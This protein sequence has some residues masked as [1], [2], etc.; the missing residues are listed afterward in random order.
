MHDSYS[1]H[2]LDIGPFYIYRFRQSEKLRQFTKP[3][4]KHQKILLYTQEKIYHMAKSYAWF[5]DNWKRYTWT[6]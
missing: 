4:Q 5:N 1:L 2:V 6:K 3:D